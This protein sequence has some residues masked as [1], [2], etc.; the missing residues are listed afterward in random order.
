MVFCHS[1]PGLLLLEP[2]FEIEPPFE[3]SPP[4]I[5]RFGRLPRLNGE[6]A[7]QPVLKPYVEACGPAWLTESP[8]LRVK[9]SRT[10]FRDTG[11]MI[12]VYPSDARWLVLSLVTP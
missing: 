5:V 12:L 1:P 9:P 7:A 2:R 8:V 4:D 6:P 3:T 10:S 11:L